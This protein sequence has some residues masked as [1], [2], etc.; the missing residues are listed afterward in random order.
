VSLLDVSSLVFGVLGV[1]YGVRCYMELW[2]WAK[3]CQNAKIAIAHNRR[4]QLTAP[5]TEWLSWANQLDKDQSSSGR[6]V[7]RN[8]KVS[9]A[10]LRPH[11]SKPVRSAIKRVHQ[12]RRNKKAAQAA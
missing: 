10:I 11:S 12:A 9:V 6:V 4:V 1:A 8:G 3:Q 2:K 5:L 7:Y